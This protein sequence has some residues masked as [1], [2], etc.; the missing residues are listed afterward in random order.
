MLKVGVFGAGHLA[1]EH[2]EHWKK[3]PG[4][5]LIGFYAPHNKNVAALTEQYGLQHFGDAD[6]LIAASDAV[7]IVSPGCNHFEIA[8]KCILNQKHVLIGQPFASSAEEASRLVKLVHEANLKCQVSQLGRYNPAFMSL[9]GKNLQPMFI[10]AHRLF[11]FDPD[12]TLSSVVM[13]IMAHDIDIV[14]HLVKSPVKRISASGVAIVSDSADIASVRMEFDNGCVANLTA[15][16]VSLKG[17]EKIRLFQRDAYISIDFLNNKTELISLKNAGEA[18]GPLNMPLQMPNGDR[19][20]IAV[21]VADI[22]LKD[23]LYMQLQDFADAILADKPVRVS[24]YD[25]FYTMDVAEQIL[26]KMSLHNEMH[27]V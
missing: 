22:E 15:S 13:D 25:G 21:E 16:R 1:K 14:L 18:T 4:T 11:T 8:E 20:A 26:K 17:M 23:A 9:A 2:I 24:V 27:N 3:I 10:E 6:E 7:D 5:L 12:A 19:K